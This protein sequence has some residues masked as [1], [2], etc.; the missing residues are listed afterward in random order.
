MWENRAKRPLPQ[1]SQRGTEGS[2]VN[3]P[4]FFLVKGTTGRPGKNVYFSKETDTIEEEFKST[5]GEGKRGRQKL[6][7]GTEGWGT[8]GRK[9]L[10]TAGI[11]AVGFG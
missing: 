6:K 8:G 11:K 2:V 7:T 9:F 1:G 5:G 3:S 4:M 10:G